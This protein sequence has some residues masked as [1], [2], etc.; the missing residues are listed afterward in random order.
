MTGADAKPLTGLRIIDLSMFVA[1]PFGT[2]LLGELGAEIIKI[3]PSG[4]DPLRSNRIGPALGEESAQFAT[5]NHGKQSIVLNLKS[6][7]G[8]GV[9]LDLAAIADVVFDNF[10]P[11]VMAR[12]RL[13]HA[14]LAQRNPRLVA[15]YG[16]M[17]PAV[18]VSVGEIIDLIDL[19][20]NHFT[21]QLC[22]QFIR[23][24]ML[25]GREIFGARKYQ[26]VRPMAA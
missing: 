6:E 5:Y 14:Q 12:L 1:G 15:V 8:R 2:T 20:R 4:G 23:Q 18:V 9:V 16:E 17:R 26:G 3:E 7:A 10:R 24:N 25:E 21:K 19:K 13:D 22:E 11:G